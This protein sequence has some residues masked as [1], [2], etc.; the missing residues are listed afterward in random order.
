M[1]NPLKIIAL[2]ALV[3]FA[4][5]SFADPS[6]SIKAPRNVVWKDFLGVNAHYLWFQPSA[7]KAQMVK[8]KELGLEW[9]RIDLHW[10]RHEPNEGQFNLATMDALYAE[11]QRQRIKS[12]AYLT[13]SAPFA[14]TAPAHATNRDQ[15]PP[16]SNVE[17]ASRLALLAKRYPG[18]N[19][20]Q[21]WN[22]P[23]IPTFWQPSEDPIGYGN[24]LSA[25]MEAL[26]TQAPNA[27]RVMGGL[28][29]YSQMP[30][31]GGSLMLQSLASQGQLKSDVVSAYHPYTNNPEGDDV[32]ARDFVVHGTQLNTMLR[33]ANVARIWATEFGWSSYAGPQEMQPIIGEVGQADYTL[34]RLALMSAMDYDKIFLFA[35]S[36][37]DARATV[38]D[39][40][41]GLLT[42]D[43]QEKPVY[44][45]LKRFLTITGP[46]LS[47]A[48]APYFGNAP[49][50]MINIA[51]TR[52]DG[53][54][55]WMFWAAQDGSVTLAL[56]G[57]ALLHDPL[58]G[59]ATQVAAGP[60][61]FYIPVK[62]TLQ[63]LVL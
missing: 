54:R 4:S 53:K 33:S 43:G 57:T 62:K 3:T 51:W 48:D 16:R 34:R 47:P 1:Y 25:S 20:W 21:A 41:Y 28:A 39:R 56:P 38:R 63:V 11:L 42:V 40:S 60:T 32:A 10:D 31:H 37:L 36:D 49:A 14:S 17:F 18:I 9:S 6:Q 27:I 45:A 26:K 23:N 46:S 22:E 12:V 55:V 59:S 29:Y 61:G 50:G 35:L 13:G 7:Y 58:S 19:G 2:V 24:L 5:Q 52:P 30:H 44:K 15:F 8:L